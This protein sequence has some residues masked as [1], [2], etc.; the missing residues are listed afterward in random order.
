MALVARAGCKSISGDPSTRNVV[1]LF[2]PLAPAPDNV[3]RS[4]I[5]YGHGNEMTIGFS[6][7][8]E[9]LSEVEGEGVRRDRSLLGRA[10]LLGRLGLRR[11]GGGLSL[12]LAGGR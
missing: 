12:A 6:L 9:G 2:K 10:F 7:L 5:R 11:G 1:E 4:R 8:R 3:S